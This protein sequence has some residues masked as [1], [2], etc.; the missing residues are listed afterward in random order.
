MTVFRFRLE[1]VL[2]WRRTERDVED[3]RLR[4]IHAELERLQGE[5]ARLQAARVTAEMEVLRAGPVE[6]R[7]L[8]ALAAYRRRL[9][10]DRQR[11]LEQSR[12]CRAR[13]DAQRARCLE[14]D[15][16]CRLLE[17]LRARKLAEH[18]LAGDREQETA[19]A[20]SYLAQWPAHQ[21]R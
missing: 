21:P 10:Q 11:V 13:A 14:A 3:Q 4:Q 20:E 17:K 5:Q 12:E 16:R 18:L 15:R 1:R 6:A 2:E 19:A 9:E 7:E 8:V